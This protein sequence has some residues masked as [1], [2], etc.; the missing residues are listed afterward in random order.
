MDD[1]LHAKTRFFSREVLKGIVRTE[2]CWIKLL[3]LSNGFHKLQTLIRKYALENIKIFSWSLG[4]IFRPRSNGH[5][6]VSALFFDKSTKCVLGSVTWLTT[7]AS[8]CFLGNYFPNQKWSTRHVKRIWLP[9]WRI[10]LGAFAKLQKKKKKTISF[11]MY[12]PPSVRPY[13]RLSV[14]VRPSVNP[15]ENTS[16]PLDGF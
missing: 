1:A 11:F 15:H 9:L 10:I 8:I 7:C 14:P 5:I 12:V 13:V 16:L 6:F 2:V 3:L 4:F